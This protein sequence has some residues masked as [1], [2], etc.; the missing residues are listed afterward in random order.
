MTWSYS[1]IRLFKQCKYCFFLSYVLGCEKKQNFFSQYGSFVHKILEQYFKSEL[2]K[3]S[4]ASYYVLNFSKFV[5]EPAPSS[6][7]ASNYFKSGLSYFSDSENLLDVDKVIGTEKRFQCDIAG[8]PFIGF[9]DIILKTEDGYAILDHKSRNLK[10]RSTRKKPTKTDEELD[11]Y[12]TQLYLYSIWAEAEYGR[13]PDM[14]SFNIFRESRMV[15]EPFKKEAQTSS[16]R[17]VED[18]IKE[19]RN[20]EDWA[21]SLDYYYCNNLCDMREH[22]EYIRMFN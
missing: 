2:D 15:N 21:P 20:E 11:S 19:I 4:L 5:T 12:L 14:L 8:Y 6:K 9:I 17:W 1:R 3:E 16:I 18:S 10:P 13:P 22:C 7:I